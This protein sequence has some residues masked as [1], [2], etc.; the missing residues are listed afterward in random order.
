[1]QRSR[2]SQEEFR[3]FL[4]AMALEGP[5]ASHLGQDTFSRTTIYGDHD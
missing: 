2:A 1:M 3:A 5:A 4:D